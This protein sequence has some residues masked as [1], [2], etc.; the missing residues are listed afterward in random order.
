MSRPDSYRNE[1]W[2]QPQPNAFTL[3]SDGFIHD[4]L[5]VLKIGQ[6]T[7]TFGFSYG[8]FLKQRENR[9]SSLDELRFWLPFRQGRTLCGLF[10]GDAFKLHYDNGV[11]THKDF[12][13]NIYGDLRAKRNLDAFGGKLGVS[14]NKKY[15]TSNFRLAVVD[16]CSY[17]Q[18]KSFFTDGRWHCEMI[19]SYDIKHREWKHCGFQLHLL[20]DKLQVLLQ[21]AGHTQNSKVRFDRFSN[22]TAGFLRN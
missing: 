19:N 21:T 10:H 4:R 16:Y 14:I 18:N 20:C 7:P 22:V 6:Q 2:L 15:W 3:Y 11:I 5:A 13:F 1:G 8:S 9:I 12:N 17:I